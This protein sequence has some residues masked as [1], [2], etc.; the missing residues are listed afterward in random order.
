[1]LFVLC[2]GMEGSPYLTIELFF[3]WAMFRDLNPLL[4]TRTMSQFLPHNIR[5]PNSAA[6]WRGLSCGYDFL[7]SVHKHEHELARCWSL[8]CDAVTSYSLCCVCCD[9]VYGVCCRVWEVYALTCMT[10]CCPSLTSALTCANRLMCICVTTQSTC[11]LLLYNVH[12][13]SVR[14]CSISTPTWLLS[15]VCAPQCLVH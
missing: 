3:C 9:D 1:M 4:G 5:L 15:L 2:A 12:L 7:G 13:L 14:A 6:W 8:D 10:C 11:G